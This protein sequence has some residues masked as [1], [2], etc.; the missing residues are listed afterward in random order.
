MINKIPSKYKLILFAVVVF[1]FLLVIGVMYSLLVGHSKSNNLGNESTTTTHNNITNKHSSENK[2]TNISTIP[3]I[4]NSN[5]TRTFNLSSLLEILSKDFGINLY[6]ELC[7]NK[8]PR[9]VRKIS[10]EVRVEL[11][12]KN[13][14]CLLS[15]YAP[16]SV[17][18]NNTYIAY[19]TKYLVDRALNLVTNGFVD[20]TSKQCKKFC[21]FVWWG[22][23]LRNILTI[24]ELN[25]LGY[26][27]LAKTFYESLNKT[28][29]YY[30]LR[31]LLDQINITLFRNALTN[32]SY[33]LQKGKLKV[34]SKQNT[35]QVG[36][37][38]IYYLILES[39]RDIRELLFKSTIPIPS[40]RDISWFDGLLKSNASRYLIGLDNFTAIWLFEK[41][42]PDILRISLQNNTTINLSDSKLFAVLPQI[43]K[44][45]AGYYIDKAFNITKIKIC[46]FGNYSFA[47]LYLVIG[48]QKGE[49]Y[50]RQIVIFNTAYKESMSNNVKCEIFD[51]KYNT[52]TYYAF[53]Q[54]A[55]VKENNNIGAIEKR[56]YSSATESNISKEENTK[57][58]TANRKENNDIQKVSSENREEQ[59]RANSMVSSII[60][61]IASSILFILKKIL[62]FALELI[63]KII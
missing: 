46:H 21:Y 57:N 25:K 44:R 41:Q 14:S 37:A 60:D 32:W 17:F 19:V 9:I 33:S 5:T 35:I 62:S 43:D 3:I 54:S 59:P 58:Q 36:Y 47:P 30:A 61:A 63:L 18:S 15:I 49:D 55:S 31:S 2:F 26:N 23:P 13:N 11:S 20:E 4:K 10:S 8:K 39:K 48:T 16:S 1:I 28:P 53:N 34:I 12:I 45:L 52:I 6:R 24:Y 42:K 51:T 27:K 22:E 56:Q 40:Q 7:S 29:Q 38:F 50:E